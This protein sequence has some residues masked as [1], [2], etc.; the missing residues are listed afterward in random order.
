MQASNV[1]A[2]KFL[3]SPNSR[4]P[5]PLMSF[6]V[7]LGYSIVKPMFVINLRC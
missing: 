6:P 1:F 4:Q 2:T 5:I 3:D 7:W